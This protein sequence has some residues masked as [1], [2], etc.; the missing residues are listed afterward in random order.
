MLADEG[1]RLEGVIS[2]DDARTAEAILR[3][4]K[5]AQEIAATEREY[6]AKAPVQRH[7][8]TAFNALCAETQA[9]P[10]RYG[11]QMAAEI[12]CDRSMLEEVLGKVIDD[13]IAGLSPPTTRPIPY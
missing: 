10:A 9:L 5:L 2:H 8:E 1:R 13:F 11:A 3:C 7:I 4:R 12:R 6:I